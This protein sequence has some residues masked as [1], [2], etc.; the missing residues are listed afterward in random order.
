MKRILALACLGAAALALSSGCTYTKIMPMDSRME[1]NWQ[2]D[3]RGERKTYTAV[4]FPF[5]DG[6][7]LEYRQSNWYRIPA[8]GLFLMFIPTEH[9]YP[10]V[11]FNHYPFVL[12]DY[13]SGQ[14]EYL[15][16]DF[17]T[18]IPKKLGEGLRE[19]GVFKEIRYA[20]NLDET[21]DMRDYDY[22]IRGRLLKCDLRIRN[23]DYGLNFFGLMDFSWVLKIFA[24]PDRTLVSEVAYQVEIVERATGRVVWSDTIKHNKRKKWVGYYYGTRM[25][26]NSANIGLYVR[27][28]KED[29][30]E[31]VNRIKKEIQ[32]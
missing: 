4:V 10:E 23:L 8:L 3:S 27:T 25:E 14:A 11:T 21:F 18:T 1:W 32:F 20:T 19:A 5:T 24:A 22:I 30:S 2:I 9:T 29:M 28:F 26:G 16:G 31:V 15:K 7:E 13:A 12:G 6:R 17:A